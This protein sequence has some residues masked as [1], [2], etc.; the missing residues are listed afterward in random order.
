MRFPIRA[1]AVQHFVFLSVHIIETMSLNTFTFDTTFAI[2]GGNA[3]SG[4]PSM[5]QT[6][7]VDVMLTSDVEKAKLVNPENI[8]QNRVSESQP[9]TT[10]KVAMTPRYNVPFDLADPPLSKVE[11]QKLIDKL[12]PAIDK[13][14]T[15]QHPTLLF[16][17]F[18]SKQ[19]CST[20]QKNIRYAVYKWSGHHIGEQSLLELVILMEDV[21]NARARHIDEN[22]APSKVLF[23]Y[24]YTE[25][26]RLNELVVNE[27]VPI[28]VNGIEQHISYLKQKDTPLS[29]IGLDRPVDTKITG[30][31]VYRSSSD[32]F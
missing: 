4:H 32:F 28:I 3:L 18:F 30:T 15:N 13:T 8:W 12:S 23:R 17:L 1:D 20:L 21:F 29:N 31:L 11:R 9:A 2:D 5:F 14:L 10:S 16:Y 22:N 27:A 24:L 6:P 26:G 7:K 25:V 19:N